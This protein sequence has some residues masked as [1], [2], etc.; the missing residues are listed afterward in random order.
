GLLLPAAPGSPSSARWSARRRG[1]RSRSGRLRRRFRAATCTY[2]RFSRSSRTSL[3]LLHL[4]LEASFGADAA[5]DAFARAFADARPAGAGLGPEPIDLLGQCL[6]LRG[7]ARI[8]V[9]GLLAPELRPARHRCL[10]LSFDSREPARR[11]NTARCVTELLGPD[12]GCSSRHG[13]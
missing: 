8:G 9:E 7:D 2:G 4:A 11:C 13:S 5:E 10:E 3:N 12:A 6:H 1:W